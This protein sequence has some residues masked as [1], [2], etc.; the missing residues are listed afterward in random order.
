M[1]MM[2]KEL[3]AYTESRRLNQVIAD[4]LHKA[5]VHDLNYRL[6]G[7]ALGWP[8]WTQRS[9]LFPFRVL[10]TSD[11]AWRWFLDPTWDG[12]AH[13]SRRRSTVSSLW[14][15]A[16]SFSWT[17]W[18]PPDQQGVFTLLRLLDHHH[19]D[20]DAL[21]LLSQALDSYFRAYSPARLVWTAPTSALES[22]SSFSPIITVYDSTADDEDASCP[23]AEDTPTHASASSLSTTDL[24]FGSPSP[25][26]SENDVSSSYRPSSS[27]FD[28]EQYRRAK[29]YAWEC[30]E[31]LNRREGLEL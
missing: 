22:I 23:H 12:D 9:R 16:L 25:S 8:Q 7:A 28:L 1:T 20:R 21:V 2:Q 10:N 15:P 30:M 13:P 3:L 27:D 6:R 11:C 17:R 19:V 4:Q 5:V 18:T 26:V 31:G 29:R 14:V 24:N